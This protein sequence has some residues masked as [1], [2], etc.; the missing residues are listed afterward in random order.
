[1][2]Y[3][4]LNIYILKIFWSNASLWFQ[5]WSKLFWLFARIQ[6]H[7]HL[8]GFTYMFIYVKFFKIYKKSGLD[9]LHTHISCV[10]QPS[11]HLNVVYVHNNNSVRL[12]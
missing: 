2:K 4:Y 11:L 8:M 7:R 3:I 1:M 10:F 6:P 12:C 9:N 5:F